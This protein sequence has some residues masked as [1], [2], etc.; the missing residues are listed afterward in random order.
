[1]HVGAILDEYADKDAIAPT[2]NDS[3]AKPSDAVDGK[4]THTKLSAQIRALY[5][6]YGKDW[7]LLI[8]V[9]SFYE[10]YGDQALE[11]HH[12]LGLLM[13]RKRLCGFPDSAVR[14]Y[15][16]KLVKDFGQRVAVID[17][18][19]GEATPEQQATSVPL[20]N[21]ETRYVKRFY[22]PA[23]TM[24]AEGE[25]NYLAAVHVTSST[26]M[27]LHRTRHH[28]TTARQ[29]ELFLTVGRN[30]RVGS[31]VRVLGKPK[32]RSGER[33]IKRSL[34]FPLTDRAELEARFDRLDALR[35]HPMVLDE[36][37]QVLD[38]I[39][40]S[41]PI[42]EICSAIDMDFAT[43]DSLKAL[44]ENLLF[45]RKLAQVLHP[46]PAFATD[47]QHLTAHD[48]LLRRLLAALDLTDSTALVLAS[49][50]PSLAEFST[51]LVRLQQ[52]VDDLRA[53]F[54]GQYGISATA[55]SPVFRAAGPKMSKRR[56]RAAAEMQKLDAELA[57]VDGL[58][59]SEEPLVGGE[60]AEHGGPAGAGA[61][62]RP[63]VELTQVQYANL[64]A[65]ARQQFPV[66][67][68]T[69][70][71]VRI[72]YEKWTRLQLAIAEL[73]SR[74]QVA[75][76]SVLQ[77]LMTRVREQIPS[78]VKTAHAIALLDMTQV[79]CTFADRFNCVRP[80][81]TDDH[82]MVLKQVIH[83]VIYESA[84]EA[85]RHVVPNDCEL[86]HDKCLIVISGANMGGKTCYMRTVGAAVILAQ[87][88]CPVPATSAQLP[89]YDAIYTRFGSYDDLAHNQ[90][91]FAAE[92]VDLR[93][94][95]SKGTPRSLVLMD[96]LG[97][98]TGPNDAMALVAAVC[99]ALVNRHVPTL[100]TTHM[101]ALVDVIRERCGGDEVADQIRC[102]H[103]ACYPVKDGDE[104]FWVVDYRMRP[105]M[106]E[107]SFGVEIASWTKLP[108]H[109]LRYA[110]EAREAL[111][112]GHLQ[113]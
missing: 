5:D 64:P 89:I 100:T 35:A 19:R 67:S 40:N 68:K 26:P 57:G 107:S 58:V 113:R 61:S 4:P 41:T 48:D 52:S 20:Q 53:E 17:Q 47:C 96:E 10:M 30:S 31:M 103:S 93:R 43:P 66:V 12:H 33:M 85:G 92:M 59:V 46:L 109:V 32:T 15:V 83:P 111:R 62:G 78:L 54:C 97:R 110:M 86:D 34:L 2:T 108:K 8:R 76:Q 45:A 3:K 70:T 22:T 49:T 9:G 71:V 6:R 106:A 16:T 7:V 28:H 50:D 80:K 1:M 11:W 101:H 79:F 95:L 51:E 88:G 55:K 27:L 39:G 102:I 77:D 87:I 18:L 14:Q 29:L 21:G 63:L 65:D 104:T 13:S 60:D 25:L 42:E 99:E 98:G 37:R 38:Q 24:V 84:L 72:E 90:S 94:I 56:M 105:G 91:T 75:E 74:V 81:F 112:V 36:V 73:R 23:T 44:L 69:K 82:T